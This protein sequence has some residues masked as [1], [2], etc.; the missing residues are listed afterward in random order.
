MTK[1][2]KRK[3]KKRDRGIVDF[4]MVMNH[5]FHSL[6]EWILEM[7]DPRNQ[8]YIKYTQ[9]DLGYMA[10]LKNVCG[11]HSMREME[12]NF[13]KETC[14]DTLRIL[15]GHQTLEEM[16]HYD[17][18]NYYLERLSPECLSELRRKMVTSLIRGKQFNRNRL[19]GKYWRV[20]LD[21]TGLFCFKEKHCENCLCTERR[22]DD[23][24]K[25]KLYYHKVLEAKI[26][27]GDSIVISLG[28]E[29][30]ENEKE[31]VEKQDCETNAAKRLM[32]RI[33][34]DYPRLPICIQ[35]DTLYATEPMM[36]LCREKYHWAYIFT[37]KDTR[38]K[39][40]DEGFEW[41]KSGGIKKAS[42][43]CEEKGTGC[44]A[45]HVEEVAG[46]KESMNVFEY[47]YEKKD[48]KGKK[49]RVRFRWI[50]SL[51]LTGKNLEEM[52]YAGRGRWKIE[53]EGFNNQKNGIY[54]IEHLNSRNSNAMK[55]HYL[56][57]QISDILMQLYLAWNP[58][59]KKLKQTVKN[60]S[61]GLLESFRG[62]TVTA[63][64]V[65][66]IYRYTTVYLE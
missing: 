35:G 46:K 52:I 54:R 12:E 1:E 56:L 45:N 44:Y 27:L 66:Y 9:A 41:I 55:N 14:I 21:G 62:L 18:L 23:G 63:E 8:S 28:T 31:N 43:L 29:F 65:S 42:G 40:L 59:I 50:S 26:V 3:Y 22:T 33:K 7:G 17:T 30:I 11:Q 64:D 47:E 36:E 58:Y 39:L 53:N 57:T 24:K 25:E 49:Y 51:E 60:T 48:K 13:N 37:Q 4:M 16:P 6:R 5:F 38:Q 19:L 34:K 15:S 10:I 2:E 32:E 20:I 61:S